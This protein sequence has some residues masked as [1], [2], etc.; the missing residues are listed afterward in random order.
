MFL[1]KVHTYGARRADS[2][3]RFFVTNNPETWVSEEDELARAPPPPTVWPHI[4]HHSGGPDQSQQ[5]PTQVRLDSFLSQHQR[6]A[7]DDC[8]L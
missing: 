6:T 3:F 2:G 8:S 4:C 7:P 5:G 1:D